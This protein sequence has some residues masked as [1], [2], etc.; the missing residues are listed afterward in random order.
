MEDKH[1][2]LIIDLRAR[3]GVKPSVLDVSTTA[4]CGVIVSHMPSLNGGSIGNH[5]TC[6]LESCHKVHT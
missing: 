1:R 6:R 5:W 3:W 4:L 2:S